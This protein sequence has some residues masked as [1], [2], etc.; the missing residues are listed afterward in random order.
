MQCVRAHYRDEVTM[1]C[2]PANLIFFPWLSEANVAGFLCKHA[3]LQSNPAAKI[4][5][6]PFL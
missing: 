4:H 3:D 1:C 5:N 6:V 2:F